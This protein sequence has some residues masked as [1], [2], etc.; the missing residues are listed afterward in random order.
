MPPK[1][2]APELIKEEPDDG[3]AITKELESM[4]HI[5]NTLCG[6]NKEQRQRVLAWAVDRFEIYIPQ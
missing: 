2:A 3:T 1:K 6:L 5:A 4:T